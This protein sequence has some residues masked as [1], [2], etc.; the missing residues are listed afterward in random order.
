MM[1]MLIANWKASMTK[2]NAIKWLD[3]FIELYNKDNL[4][5]KLKK[6]NTQIVIC[7]P[8]TLIP[9]VHQ[10]LKNYSSITVGSQTVSSKPSGPYTGEVTAELLKDYVTHA[11]IGH[12]ERRK[13]FQLTEELI[14]DQLKNCIDN[15]I[16]PILCIRDEQDKVHDNAN[17]IAFEPPDAIGTGHNAD[18]KDVIAM[19]KQLQLKP[20]T[21]FMYG[22]SVAGS[23]ITEYI[24]TGEIQGF[25]VGTASLKASSFYN[26][27]V[28]ML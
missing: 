9:I 2:P 27:A 7:P 20:E 5:T 12:S 14:A 17:I 13:H 8:F 1:K 11:I 22:A 19:K 23:N 28:A 24:K 25:L 4:D 16:V 26:L 6:N 10:Y 15:G 21:S 3:E 18:V